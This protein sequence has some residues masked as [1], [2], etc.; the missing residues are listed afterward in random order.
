M[1]KILL[2]FDGV[3]FS[4]G[5]LEFARK[6]SETDPLMLTGIFLPQNDYADMLTYSAG[7]IAAPLFIPPVLEEDVAKLEKNILRFSTWCINNGIDYKVHKDF[8]DFAVLE[9]EKESLFADLMIIGSEVFY[10]GISY[11][12]PNDHLTD[13]LHMAKCPVITVPEKYVFPKINI[14]AYD[15]SDA[16]VY[17]I[18][19]FAYLFPALADNKTLL[20]YTSADPDTEIPD[21]PFIEELAVKHYKDLTVAKLNFD[22]KKFFSVWT[23]EEKPAIVISGSFGRSGLS[24]LFKKSFVADIIHEHETPVFIAHQ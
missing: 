20:T 17:A 4:E 13:I 16:S 18:K 9:L 1:K 3:H 10:A 7:S 14:L 11:T 24:R 6:L 19:Q 8:N 15:G 2:V 12:N 22:P 21:E 5:A 23:S